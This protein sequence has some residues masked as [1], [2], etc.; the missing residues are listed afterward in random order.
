MRS[1]LLVPTVMTNGA[2]PSDDGN[3]PT[4]QQPHAKTFLRRLGIRKPS[5]MSLTSPKPSSRTA[6]TFSLDDLLRPQVPSKV[7]TIPPL[8]SIYSHFSVY[9]FTLCILHRH[10]SI[11]IYS[12]IFFFFFSIIR[13]LCYSNIFVIVI[14][15][16]IITT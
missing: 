4:A 11:Y 14:I 1:E 8:S 2:T 16:I 7:S 9:I 12:C 15:T 5:L 3:S 6:R 13:H 10:F